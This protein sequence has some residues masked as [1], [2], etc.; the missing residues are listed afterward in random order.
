M[1]K[2]IAFTS[3]A[4]ILV[5]FFSLCSCGQDPDLKNINTL[6]DEDDGVNVVEVKITSPGGLTLNQKYVINRTK[7]T[8][9]YT[10][11]SFNKIQTGGTNEDSYKSSESS[12]FKLNDPSITIMPNFKFNN[13]TVTNRTVNGTTLRG[14]VPSLKKFMGL[15]IDTDDA[16]VEVFY[17][18]N[19]VNTVTVTFTSDSGNTV[20]LK[21]RF[22]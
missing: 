16:K 2:Y 20:T 5:I 6:L 1:K 11:E 21:Y 3:I 9:E 15:D 7:N 18:V 4:L 8:I 19:A 22:N 13:S 14:D 12:V 10:G 17:N